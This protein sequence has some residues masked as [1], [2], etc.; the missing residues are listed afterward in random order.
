[1]KTP[2]KYLVVTVKE[3]NHISLARPLPNNSE[4]CSPEDAFNACTQAVNKYLLQ[5]VKIVKEG[6][7]PFLTPKEI[8]NFYSISFSA[9]TAFCKDTDMDS[10]LMAHR[11]HDLYLVPHNLTFY[12][13][14][15]EAVNPFC[16]KS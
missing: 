3:G 4:C 13:Q 2:I 15:V 11:F 9:L 5:N 14:K 7:S 12:L 10:Y 16:G 6:Q 8:D 1:M